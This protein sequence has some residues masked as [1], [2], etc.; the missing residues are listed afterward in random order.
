MDSK[1]KHNQRFAHHFKPDFRLCMHTI[2]DCS[3]TKQKL[4]SI[5]LAIDR[6]N[7]EFGK[8]NID[9]RINFTFMVVALCFHSV[10]A[11]LVWQLL[12]Y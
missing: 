3:V 6:T 8:H 10:T 5:V 4:K 9:R 1:Y 7:W 12:S 2:F 11:S